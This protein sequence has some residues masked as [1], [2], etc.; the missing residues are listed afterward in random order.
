MASSIQTDMLP[1]IY[2][3]FPERPEFD[4]YAKMDP[5]SKL[6]LYT[7]GVPEAT[8]SNNEMFG[9]ERTLEALNGNPNADPETI[10]TNVRRSVDDFVQEAE[11]FDDLTML[12][13]KYNGN[14]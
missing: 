1:N 8:D 10:L 11:Q 4:I 6:F 13:M 3:A 2:P 5:G 9:A 12:C 7:D 14:Q